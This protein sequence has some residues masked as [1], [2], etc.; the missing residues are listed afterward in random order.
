MRSLRTRSR[1][2]RRRSFFFIIPFVF[3]LTL[4]LASCGSNGGTG[5]GGS[6]PT[7]APKTPVSIGAGTA[8]GCP[9]STIVNSPQSKPDV[10][11]LATTTGTVTAHNGNLIEVRLPFGQRWGGPTTSQGV[12]QLQQPA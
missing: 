6:T 11:I 8:E 1:I 10:T 7:P 3:I 12:L 4:V 5:A 2:I 9:N